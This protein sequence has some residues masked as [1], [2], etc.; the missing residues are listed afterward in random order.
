[1]T[2]KGKGARVAAGI[3]T[4]DIINHMSAANVTILSPSL[5]RLSLIHLRTP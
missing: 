5:A 4:C 1:M 3:Q 2:Y